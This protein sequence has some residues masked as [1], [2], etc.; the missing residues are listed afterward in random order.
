MSHK[1][2]LNPDQIIALLQ[3]LSDNESEGRELSELE[4]ASDVENFYLHHLKVKTLKA[5]R[6]QKIYIYKYQSIHSW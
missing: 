4:G 1:R 2:E 6:M 3:E 5:M